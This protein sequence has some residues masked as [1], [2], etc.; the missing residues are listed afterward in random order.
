MKLSSRLVVI[1]VAAAVPA[2][3]AQ[4][5]PPTC[6]GFMTRLRDAGRALTFPL[7]A[8]KIERDP[9]TINQYISK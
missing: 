3:A 7:P 5:E 9:Y 6:D 4:A 2:M 1:A 8:V